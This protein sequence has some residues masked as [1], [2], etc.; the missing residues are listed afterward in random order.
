MCSFTV[1]VHVWLS[2]LSLTSLTYMKPIFTN[3]GQSLTETLPG[4]CGPLARRLSPKPQP[5]VIN[6]IKIIICDTIN[7]VKIIK[8]EEKQCLLFI[9][10]TLICLWPFVF[11]CLYTWIVNNSYKIRITMST[12]LISVWTWWPCLL[13]LWKMSPQVNS[14]SAVFQRCFKGSENAKLHRFPKK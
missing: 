12:N 1:Y 8:E 4:C 7:S 6:L 9:A 2:L 14:V 3:Y 13:L 5:K 11:S 10:F